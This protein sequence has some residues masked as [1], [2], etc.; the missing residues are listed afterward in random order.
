MNLVFMNRTE[1]LGMQRNRDFA[2]AHLG[3]KL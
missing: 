3:A 1:H 2:V